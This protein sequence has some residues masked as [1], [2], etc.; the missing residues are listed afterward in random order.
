M[1]AVASVFHMPLSDTCADM[2]LSVF[3]PF[4]AEEFLRALKPGG[5]FMKVGPGPAASMGLKQVSMM[6][7]MKP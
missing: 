2:V 1:Y 6:S 4:E 7:R 5:R 3:A